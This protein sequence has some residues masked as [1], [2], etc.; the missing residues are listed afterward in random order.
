L[1]LILGTWATGFGIFSMPSEAMLQIQP[2]FEFYPA[3]QT[4]G[5]LAMFKILM[6]AGDVMA[7]LLVRWMIMY[8]T[9]DEKKAN[10]GFA[11]LFLSPIVL[12]E[13]SIHG[14]FDIY[15]GLLSLMSIY[16]VL[17]KR[18]AFAGMSWAIATLFKIF[19]AYLFPVLIAF[20]LREYKGDWKVAAKSIA[21]AAIAALSIFIILYLPQILNGTF[22][23]SWEFL[24]GRVFKAGSSPEKLIKIAI[25]GV[26]GIV[27]LVA[28]F[29]FLRRKV[30]ITYR[31]KPLTA[32]K[33][34]AIMLSMVVVVFAL[35]AL[36]NG[37]I[38]NLFSNL[39]HTSYIVGIAVQGIAMIVAIVLGYK[40]YNSNWEDRAKLLL[41]VG[42]LAIATCFLWVPMPEYLILLL[43]LISVYALVY[44][45][46]YITPFLF[47]S[48]GATI[49]I[50]MVEGPAALFVS[51]AQYT[52]LI[53]ISLVLDIT[54]F[55]TGSVG[56]GDYSILQLIFCAIG[57]GTQLIGVIMLFVYRFNP[58]RL[59]DEA[60]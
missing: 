33:S 39:F 24:I 40:M 10:A 27:V 45:R 28:G 50:I 47:I 31:P 38:T 35:L 32:K 22:L 11:L 9:N 5:F 52:D 26:I 56:L 19:P 23:D 43:P 29:V 8:F 54:E 42:T 58:Y 34:I 7:A 30:H 25:V 51:V 55:Y 59:E 15:C 37:G 53:D 41:M 48:I 57:A 12:V 6:I 4:I 21:I 60:I 44:D 46:R 2:Y 17:N 18:Y 20:I 49:F 13:S 14:M 1:S 3:L 36:V 16:F